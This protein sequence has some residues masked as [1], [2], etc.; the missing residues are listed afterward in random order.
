MLQIEWLQIHTKVIQNR[1]SESKI[2]NLFISIL[3]LV[4]LKKDTLQKFPYFVY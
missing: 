2:E 4:F 1:T 3:V